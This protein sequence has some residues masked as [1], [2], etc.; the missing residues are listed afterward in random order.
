MQ[1]QIPHLKACPVIA[2]YLW[3]GF[4]YVRDRVVPK[5][6]WGNIYE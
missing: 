6:E 4:Y 1:R 2:L 5:K 3:A